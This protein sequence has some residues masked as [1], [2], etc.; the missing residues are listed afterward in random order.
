MPSPTFPVP[1]G[2][3]VPSPSRRPSQ[4]VVVGSGITSIT[5]LT[6]EAIAHMKEADKVYYT[7][8]NSAT[9]IYIQKL[10]KNVFD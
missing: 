5:Q 4:L 3:A 2:I 10:N 1:K 9:D 7:V 8:E 6:L